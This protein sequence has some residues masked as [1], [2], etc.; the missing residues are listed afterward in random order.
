MLKL[1]YKVIALTSV[2]L[3][4][5]SSQVFNVLAIDFKDVP[6]NFWAYQYISDTSDIITGDAAGYFKPNDQISK[7]DT[8]KIFAKAAGYKY[9]NFTTDEKNSYDNAYNKYKSLL[10]N[11]D[12]RYIKWSNVADREIAYLLDK[13][14]FVQSDLDKFIV[15]EASTE[16]LRALSKEEAA[17]YLTRLIS[18]LCEQLDKSG[19]SNMTKFSDDNLIDNNYKSDIDY[20][21]KSG[22]INGDTDNKFNPKSAVTKTILSVMMSRTLKFI[23]DFNARKVQKIESISGVIDKY[24][25]GVDAVQIVLASGEKKIYKISSGANIKIDGVTKN[26]GELKENM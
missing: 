26:S 19:T 2:I 25:P 3:G 5:S 7:F 23:S 14:I 1:N 9:V 4:L 11:Y 10:E 8:A 13:N 22:I 18:S 15:K 12:Q 24:Y 6:Q 20:L 16:K 21:Y 17:V